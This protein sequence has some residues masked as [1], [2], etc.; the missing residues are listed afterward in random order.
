MKKTILT[1]LVFL[2]AESVRLLRRIAYDK[3]CPAESAVSARTDAAA[4]PV[5]TP[6]QNA[7]DAV[8]LD[9]THEN[10]VS[11]KMQLLAGTLSLTGRP[12]CHQGTGERVAASLERPQDRQHEHGPG[13]GAPGPGPGR[14][15]PQPQSASTETQA[16]IDALVSQIQAAMTPEQIK[17]IAAMKITQDSVMTILQA[18][19]ITMGGPQPGNG[20]RPTAPGSAGRNPARRATTAGWSVT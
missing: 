1:V 4:S 15:T 7:S 20:L 11:A 12:G 5:A 3:P 13:Q 14:A 9:T 17:V 19:G 2:C 6:A 18:Q 8:G 16:Q 10:A